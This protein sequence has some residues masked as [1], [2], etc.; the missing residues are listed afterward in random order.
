MAVTARWY[1][2]AAH[3]MFLGNIKSTDTIKIALL[4]SAG[5]Y[6]TS[7]TTWSD[8]SAQEITPTAVYTTGGKATTITASSDTTASY[9]STSS[10][11]WE[12][13]TF[14]FHHAVVYSSTSGALVL[15]L[16]FGGAQAPNGQDYQINVPSPAP[17]A[18][19]AS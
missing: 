19:P 8:I 5:T 12:L 16:D 10:V 4:T 2:S 9:F 6:D 7:D 13:A 11:L 14:T 3:Q 18:T 1:P 15:H 17:S